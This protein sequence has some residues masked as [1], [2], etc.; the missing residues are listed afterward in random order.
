MKITIGKFRTATG[1]VPV[2]FEH[3]GVR[4]RRDVNACLT[5]AGKFNAKATA[6]RVEEVALGVAHKI[7]LGVIANPEP[8]PA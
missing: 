2:T 1:T 3:E 6:A 8:D 5:D 4:H 7:E